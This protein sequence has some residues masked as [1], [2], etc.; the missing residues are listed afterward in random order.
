MIAYKDIVK[1]PPLPFLGNKR[2]WMRVLHEY[3]QTREVP[4]VVVDVFGGSGLCANFFKQISPGSRV[5]WNDFDD[6]KSR[7]DKIEQTNMILKDIQ[8]YVKEHDVSELYVSETCHT[9]RPK[10]LPER[11]AE[12]REIIEK[13]NEPDYTTLNLNFTLLGQK[14]RGT[15]PSKIWYSKI[16]QSPYNA[17]GYLNGVERVSMDF[18]E[19]L[20]VCKKKCEEDNTKALFILDPPYIKTNAGEYRQPQSIKDF[21]DLLKF[22]E[23]TS[24]SFIAFTSSTSLL[25]P[26]IEYFHPT[27]ESFC[28]EKLTKK[29]NAGLNKAWDE[30]AYIKH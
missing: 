6:Y 12:M 26:I 3:F 10:F 14:E 1:Q 15:L 18:R 29:Q 20:N 22:M 11:V 19:L 4:R 9:K 27:L 25:P 16:R 24:H 21:F 8:N 23:E 28:D 13:Y 2:N 7:L 30:I 5:I 17:D